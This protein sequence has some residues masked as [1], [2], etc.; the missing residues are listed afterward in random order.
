MSLRKN[1]RINRTLSIDSPGLDSWC[2]WGKIVKVEWEKTKKDRERVKMDQGDLAKASAFEWRGAAALRCLGYGCFFK[3][4]SQWEAV[5]VGQTKDHVTGF[6]QK[7]RHG[8]QG[9]LTQRKAAELSPPLFLTIT[10]WLMCLIMSITFQ[11][12]ECL[13]YVRILINRKAWRHKLNCLWYENLLAWFYN[14]LLFHSSSVSTIL[15]SW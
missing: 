9:L 12:T 3:Q 10:V 14:M 11:T 6:Q 5:M 15:E 7:R 1:Q 4:I 13:L 2:P 8:G